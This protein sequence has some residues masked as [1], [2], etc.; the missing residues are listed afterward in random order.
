[1]LSQDTTHPCH[2][3]PAA[4][5]GWFLMDDHTDARWYNGCAI[6]IEGTMKLSP[7]GEAWV[8]A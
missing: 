2:V 3:V 7:G 8:D 6:E 5:C 1:M 4:L